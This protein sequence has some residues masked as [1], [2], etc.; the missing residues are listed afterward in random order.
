MSEPPH[1]PVALRPP[2]P[3]DLSWL[4]HRHMVVM[5]P[6]Y[7]WDGRYEAHLAQIVAE[8]LSG[9]DVGA[10][11]FWV[12]ERDGEILG[13]VGLT[14]VDA[15]RGRL[16][17]LFVEPDA[18]GLGL[19]RRL[20]DACVAFAREAGYAEVVLWTVDVLYAARRIYAAAGFRLIGSEPSELS[21]GMADE[22]WLLQL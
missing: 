4:Q 5:A 8:F 16:R 19:G 22:T 7:G 13:C 2:K 1:P 15:R 17:L 18:R 21:E 11:R 10:E 12:A 6:A 14:R 20:V 9:R 3:G